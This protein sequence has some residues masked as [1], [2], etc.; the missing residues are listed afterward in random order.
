M[1]TLGSQVAILF[2]SD[3]TIQEDFF[4]ARADLFARIV[5]LTAGEGE[6]LMLGLANG[7]LTTTEIVEAILV[8]GP[9]D[10]NDRVKQERAERAVWILAQADH[11]PGDLDL[12]FKGENGGT[13]VIVKPKWIFS[14]PEG[15][16]YF[17]YNSGSALT[18][19]AVAT[20]VTTQ[21]GR[22]IP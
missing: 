11:G 9:S 19:G 6:G 1:S 12:S 20:M 8:D 16:N 10:L 14:D 2:G 13:K 3:I 22:W 18:T 17:I 4:L 7:E 5:G 21:Y 15:W